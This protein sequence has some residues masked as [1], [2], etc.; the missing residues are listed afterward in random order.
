VSVYIF[1]CW[2][3]SVGTRTMEWSLPVCWETDIG[4]YRHQSGCHYFVLH[5][6][7]GFI[8]NGAKQYWWAGG[9]GWRVGDS[10]FQQDDLTS[11][12]Q[13]SFIHKVCVFTHTSTYT[14]NIFPNGMLRK[15]LSRWSNIQVRSLLDAKVPLVV[16]KLYQGCLMPLIIRPC[17]HYTTYSGAERGPHGIEKLPKLHWIRSYI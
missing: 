16:S 17:L 1:L 12:L 2:R 10:P 8:K 3:M 15:Q 13:L 11:C 4:R 7:M 14:T 6:L 9:R 5:P